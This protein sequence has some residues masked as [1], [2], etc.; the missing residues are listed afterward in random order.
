MLYV[1][2]CIEEY[3]GGSEELWARAL[4]YILQKEAATLIK[5]RINKEV[6]GIQKLNR[7]GLRFLEL[8]GKKKYLK[9]KIRNRLR[10]FLS[11]KRE[12]QLFL[13]NYL[14][15]FDELLSSNQPKLVIIAQG[16]NFDGLS[17]AS[18][19][20][21]KKVPYVLICQKAVDFYWPEDHQR[22]HMK[23]ALLGARKHF[24]VARHN[25]RVTEEQFGMALPNKQL[26][27]NPIK[28]KKNVL[29]LPSMDDTCRFLCVARLF[30]LDKGQ[31]MLLKVLS[32]E[33]W[34]SRKVCVDFLGEGVDE[35]QLKGLVAFY[36]LP[37]VRFLGHQADVES[38]WK[39]YHALILPS[40]SEGMPL[41][42]QEAMALGRVVICTDAGGNAELVQDGVS[43][44]VGQAS[45]SG[46]DDAMERAW[47]YR[48][49]WPE[50]GLA[51]SKRINEYV[52]ENPEKYFSEQI[53]QLL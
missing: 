50:M 28:V 5:K 7:L 51:A 34:R 39:D 3:W 8:K 35:R 25:M 47:Q 1:I 21:K 22:A 20:F 6:P 38:L 29:P 2:S 18:L 48:M 43:G 41:S 44:F 11:S 26:V 27:Y 36:Q 19:C 53:L 24:F 12:N 9:E 10:F 45:I 37:N 32:L 42:I 13:S 46:L 15:R 30:V 49:A 23:E 4:P 16:M 40:R 17:Y 31:D 52:P 14:Y 33:K